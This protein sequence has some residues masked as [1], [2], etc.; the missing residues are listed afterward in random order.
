MKFVQLLTCLREGKCTDED[1]DMLNSRR[2]DRC[3]PQMLAAQDWTNIPVIV[4]DNAIKDVLN[5]FAAMK[6]TDATNQDLHWYCA[7]DIYKGVVVANQGLVAHL[8]RLG[9]GKTGQMLGKIPLGLGMPI[10]VLHNFDMEHGIVNGA[11][12]LLTGIWYRL[13]A[14]ED[15]ILTSCSVTLHNPTGD[16]MPWLAADEVPILAESTSFTISHHYWKTAQTFKRIQVPLSP[17][18]A[19]TAHRSQ[20]QSLEKVV[21]DLKNVHGSE[22]PYVMVS[23][24]KSL[25]GLFVLRPF[26]KKKIMCGLSEEA[27]VENRRLYFLSLITIV[28]YGSHDARTRALQLLSVDP[29]LSSSAPLS[30]SSACLSVAFGNPDLSA[31]E[32]TRVL[33]NLVDDIVKRPRPASGA[34]KRLLKKARLE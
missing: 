4:T 33:S 22:A 11:R 16:Q 26:A 28:R 32:I 30:V 19:L 9:S 21:V 14:K 12:G 25:Q 27:R 8:R 31:V 13:N 6:F 5:S 10:Y 15:R 2:I 1:F 34:D 23:R 18:F 3:D 24:A 29:Q 20:G 17:A 7:E